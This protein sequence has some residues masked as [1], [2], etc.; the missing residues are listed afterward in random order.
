MADRPRDLLDM[1]DAGPKVIRGSL[2][3]VAG[4][5]A[6]VV[7]GVGASA[8]MFRHL[9]VVD[10]GRYVTVLALIAIVGGVS[11]LGLTAVGVREYTT[12]HGPDRDHF[13]RNLIGMR[14][15]FTVAGVCVAAAF[16][17]AAGYPSEMVAGTALAGAG[18]VLFIYQQSLS[19]ALQAELRL[20]WVTAIQLMAQALQAAAVVALVLAAAGL[21]PFLA[22]QLPVMVPLIALTAWLVQRSSPLLPAARGSEWAAVMRDVLPYSAAVVFAVV[23]F[24]LIAVLVSVLST[25]RETGYFGVAFRVIDTVALIPPLLVS[26][27]FPVLARA[28]RDDRAR[29]SYAVTRLS[30]GMLLLGAW[31]ALCLFVGAEVAIDVVAGPDFGPSVD[32]LRVLAVALLGSFLLAT[33]GYALLSLHCHRAIL[34]AN[35][36]ALGVAAVAGAVL[37]PSEGASGGAV[38]LAIAELTLAAGYG[39]ALVRVEPSLRKAA[40]TAWRTAL[41]LGAALA[42][43]LLPG[44]GPLVGTIVAT[45]VYFGVLAATGAIPWEVRDAL[46][47]PLRERREASGQRR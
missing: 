38:A 6:G 19:T 33:W 29:L 47:R 40:G 12:R 17:L 20:G 32:V 37:I 11:D 2:L 41:A 13:M 27:A 42:A 8:L 24:R 35:A 4:Y 16:A 25:E 46:T 14:V 31:I 30:E 3:R 18:F 1:P 26:S 23:Y 10:S 15:T 34:I 22:V 5:I 43:A 7:L 28:A 45:A 44:L 21:V 9:G 39:V 36:F